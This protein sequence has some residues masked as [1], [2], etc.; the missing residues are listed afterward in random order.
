QSQGAR[1]VAWNLVDTAP[2]LM[3]SAYFTSEK[4]LAD[5]PD[6]VKDFTAA[7]NESLEYADGHPDEVREIVQ[8]YP[9]IDAALLEKV[10][11]PLWPTEINEE[12]TKKLAEL[13]QQDGL[14]KKPVDV[15]SMLP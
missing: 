6:L 7:I 15:D 8:T 11:L 9:D 13:A 10:T 5:D 14:V 4:L 3:I 2:D 12:S 1:V